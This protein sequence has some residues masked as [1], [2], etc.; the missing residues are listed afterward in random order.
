MA[1]SK[2]LLATFELLSEKL[3]EQLNDEEMESTMAELSTVQERHEPTAGMEPELEPGPDLNS[4][5]D[6]SP[7]PDSN[8]DLNRDPD[9]DLD[10]DPK[11][12]PDPKT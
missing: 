7:N 1:A 3:C 4:N 6:P 10:P 9:P 11:S 2:A 8:L 5:M 12:D